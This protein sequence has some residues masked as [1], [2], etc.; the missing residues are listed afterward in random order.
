MSLRGRLGRLEQHLGAKDRCPPGR[1][2][3]PPIAMLTQF[4]DG[5]FFDE[6]TGAP[7]TDPDPAD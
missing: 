6:H 5:R 2:E 3:L 1:C 4:P 7:A